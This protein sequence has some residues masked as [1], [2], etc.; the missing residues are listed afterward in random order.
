LDLDVFCL[1]DRLYFFKWNLIEF[2]FDFLKISSFRAFL[3][4]LFIIFKKIR[5]KFCKSWETNNKL[6]HKTRY[7]KNVHG[8]NKFLN[9]WQR[10][11]SFFYPLQA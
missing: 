3:S 2:L 10:F 6:V 8:H 5:S 4:K 1:C 9:Y 11:E 7:I